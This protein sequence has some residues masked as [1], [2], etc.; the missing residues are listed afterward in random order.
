[1]PSLEFVRTRTLCSGSRWADLR[2]TV[3]CTRRRES[4]GHSNKVQVPRLRSPSHWRLQR[5]MEG[6]LR[7][8][9][10]LRWRLQL[11]VPVLVVAIATT[12][13]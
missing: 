2:T 13:V 4:A 3:C 11:R 5:L 9:H 6:P 8:L 10:L 12:T 7:S 1:M